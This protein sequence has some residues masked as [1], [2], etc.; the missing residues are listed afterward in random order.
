MRERRAS[1]WRARGGGGDGDAGMITLTEASRA[2]ICEE[3]AIPMSEVMHA[4]DEVVRAARPPTRRP[5]PSQRAPRRAVRSRDR[6]GGCTDNPTSP[7]PTLADPP[8]PN[9]AL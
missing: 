5:S 9:E 1:E 2:E 8:L 6:S 3:T 7:E 4:L